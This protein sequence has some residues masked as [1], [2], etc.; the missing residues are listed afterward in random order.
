MEGCSTVSEVLHVILGAETLARAQ[1][2]KNQKRLI[3]RYHKIKVLTKAKIM[4]LSIY[5]MYLRV[6]LE[7]EH[8]KGLNIRKIQ[9]HR[10]GR[11]GRRRVRQK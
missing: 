7:K 8:S 2:E 1:L 11:G 9:K 5:L 4:E 10:T 3:K 6:R